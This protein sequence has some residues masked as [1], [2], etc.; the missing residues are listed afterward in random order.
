MT[1]L[2]FIGQYRH[3]ALCC[4]V[5]DTNKFAQDLNVFAIKMVKTY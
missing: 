4:V 5:E 2:C 3:V 1:I